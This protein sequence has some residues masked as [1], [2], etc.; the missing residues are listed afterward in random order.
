VPHRRI[1]ALTQPAGAAGWRCFLGGAGL[2]AAGWL[3][4]GPAW[5]ADPLPYSVSLAKTGIGKLDA[6]LAGSLQLNALRTRAPA[7][8]FAVLTRA[9]Q[10]LP[11]MTAAL[12]SFGYYQSHITVTVAGHPLADPDLPDVLEARPVDPPAPIVIAV[13][14][15]KLFHLRYVALVG[16]LPESARAAFALRRGDPAVAGNVL[17]AGGAVL[18]DLREH[19][20]ALAT[21]DAPDAVLVPSEQALDVTLHATAGPRVDLGPITITGLRRVN[22]SYVRRRLLIS[23]GQLFQ[24]SALEAARQDL[25]ATGVFSGVVVRT[26]P[27]LDA[28]GE[29]PVTVDVAER[30]R[31]AVSFNVAYSTDLGGSAG[32]TW[33]HRNLFGNAEQLNLAAAI[34]G[35][36]GTA[37]TAVGYNVTAQLIKPDFLRRDQSLQFD[38]GALKQSLDAYDQKAITAGVTLT[39]KL[40]KQWTASVGLTAE[41]E[42]ITQEGVVR[43]Y[44]LVALPVSGKF[45]STALS[46]PLDDPT[47]GIRAALS[48]TPTESLGHR[49]ATFVILQGSASTYFDFAALGWSKPGRTVVAVRGLVGSAQGAGNFDLPPDQRFYG[50]GSATVRGFKYQSVGP[51]FPDDNPVG[52]AAIDA[53]GVELRQRVWGNIGAALFADAAQVNESSSPFQGTLREGVGAGVR[54][55]TPIGPVRVD[56]AVP[57]NKPPGGDSFELYLGLGQAF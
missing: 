12:E 4:G 53:V 50:G 17:A 40:S 23:Q 3:A 49:D 30:A 45:D 8:P 46:N 43:D 24:P 1:S 34:S 7:G 52:G 38:L 2:V 11:R 5:A 37:V 35:L 55:Y 29:L 39:R 31:H 28:Q 27:G 26:A 16:A 48:A 13:E 19:G 51:L 14:T 22:E 54:Y 42:E 57:V 36:G 21:V 47:H 15:G 18:N 32:A 20:Y 33:T 25:A 41:E 6:A 10:D 9:R 56:V 44:T